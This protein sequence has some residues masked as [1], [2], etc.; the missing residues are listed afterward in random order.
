MIDTA[1]SFWSYYVSM[2]KDYWIHMTPM[3]YGYLLVFIF[4]A[5][6]FLLKS[7]IRRT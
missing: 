3:R 6:F 1:R 7:N 5:G 2:A 4:I